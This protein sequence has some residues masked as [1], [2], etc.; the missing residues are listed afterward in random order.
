M[1]RNSIQ[2]TIL[3]GFF[4]GCAATPQRALIKDSERYIETGQIISSATG[5]I[6]TFDEMIADLSGRRIVY[7]G[8]NHTNP[9]HHGIQLKI[10]QALSTND[11]N[12]AVG[13]EMFAV[14]YQSVLDQWTEGLLSQEEFI[15]KTHWYANWRY[16]FSLYAEILTFIKDNDIPL[17]GLN[18]PFHIPRKIRIGGIDSLLGCDRQD[19]PDNIDTTDA[20]HR[21]HL[22][23]IFNQ[24]QFH[25]EANFEFFYQA[26]CVWEDT[27][28]SAVVRNLNDRQMVVLVGNGHIIHRFGIPDRA[29]KRA[30]T[31]YRS[32]YLAS[33]GETVELSFADYIWVT[34]AAGK[35]GMR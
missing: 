7:V 13:M 27:M 31:P 32:V 20:A 12:L 24:H 21:D 15:E 33:S 22:E 30:Q 11:E 25:G 17:I 18:I 16:D 34:P 23:K 10:L 35:R 4:F 14:T 26:Q 3:T 29:Y 9:L 6:V 5:A 28:A 2:L 1:I 19:L 8:E